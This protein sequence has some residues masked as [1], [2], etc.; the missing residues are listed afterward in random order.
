MPDEPASAILPVAQLPTGHRCRV[1][2][3][4]YAD[5]GSWYRAHAGHVPVQAAWGL[6]QYMARHGC[7]FAEAFT[8]LTGPRGPLILIEPPDPDR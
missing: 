3:L 1:D 7:S 6:A 2:D 4:A 8:A 5:V